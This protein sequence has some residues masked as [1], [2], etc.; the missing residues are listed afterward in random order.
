MNLFQT[1]THCQTYSTISSNCVLEN[2]IYSDIFGKCLRWNDIC[3]CIPIHLCIFWI[4]Q[5]TYEKILMFLQNLWTFLMWLNLILM[6]NFLQIRNIYLHSNLKWYFLFVCLC[7]LSR[8]GFPKNNTVSV[9]FTA[10][11]FSKLWSVK[12]KYSTLVSSLLSHSLLLECWILIWL[13]QSPLT[14]LTM[15]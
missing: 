1:W 14:P 6:L 2:L 8:N 12:I 10:P 11:S 9:S 3:V 7:H 13:S 5:F 15:L 4:H